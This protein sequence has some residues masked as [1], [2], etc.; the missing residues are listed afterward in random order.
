MGKKYREGDAAKAQIS[1]AEEKKR[2]AKTRR[3]LA[4]ERYL[5]GK[6]GPTH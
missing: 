5:A 6:D 1:V 3:E 2:F 4:A